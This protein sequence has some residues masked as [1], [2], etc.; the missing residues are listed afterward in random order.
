[1]TLQSNLE[2]FR[3]SYHVSKCLPKE[4]NITYCFKEIHDA[5]KAAHEA[6]ILIDKMK[7]PLVALH[8]SS[9]NFF[10]VQSQEYEG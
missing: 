4:D 10:I 9:C 3:T 7:L 1:M 5:S 2:K 6:N 8:R